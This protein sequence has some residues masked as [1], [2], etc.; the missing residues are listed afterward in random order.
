MTFGIF[1]LERGAPERY[2]SRN[3][4]RHGHTSSNKQQ[5]FR[6][7]IRTRNFQPSS[8][9]SS[10]KVTV[11]SH[12][13][14]QCS[15]FDQRFS[16]YPWFITTPNSRLTSSLFA[17]L[18]QNNVRPMSD[19]GGEPL[20]TRTYVIDI[21]DVPTKTPGDQ[22]PP[23]YRRQ[24]TETHGQGPPLYRRQDTE[25]HGQGLSEEGLPYTKQILS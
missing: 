16:P 8:P 25:T 10:C 2:S 19:S 1:F 22:G 23:L 17:K 4:K 9:Q 21:T 24:D 14:N 5:S 18:A 20:Q 12:V 13:N 11:D 3:H 7:R 15:L 6:E